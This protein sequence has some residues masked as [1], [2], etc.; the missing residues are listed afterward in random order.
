MPTKYLTIKF[1]E[2]PEEGDKIR[3]AIADDTATFGVY[4]FSNGEYDA[5]LT[6]KQQ[7]GKTCNSIMAFNSDWSMRSSF[8]SPGVVG[9]EAPGVI[10]TGDTLSGF[11]YDA[12]F[13]GAQAV[14]VGQFDE[15]NG[16]SS[17][18]MV[19]IDR[20]GNLLANLSTSFGSATINCVRYDSSYGILFGTSTT[21]FNGTTVRGFSRLSSGFSLDTTFNN[22]VI[23][24]GLVN[25]TTQVTALEVCPTTD[26]IYVGY[27]NSTGGGRVVRFNTDGT[28][29]ATFTAVV[30][31]NATTGSLVFIRSIAIDPNNGF[32]L[33]GGNFNDVNSTAQRLVV[34]V[35]NT[36]TPQDFITLSG[37]TDCRAI[38]L[39]EDGDIAYIGV[40][41]T[42]VTKDIIPAQTIYDISGKG[43]IKVETASGDTSN[44]FNEIIGSGIRCY[45]GNTTYLVND[46]Q[47]VEQYGIDNRKMLA[48]GGKFKT[49]GDFRAE[50]FACF[51]LEFGV[52]AIWTDVNDAVPQVDTLKFTTNFNSE[53]NRLL[54][55]KVSQGGGLTTLPNMFLALGS[56]DIL[57][58]IQVDTQF[59]PSGSAPYGTFNI[60][61]NIEIGQYKTNT[62]SVTFTFSQANECEGDMSILLGNIYNP[63]TNTYDAIGETF[64]FRYDPDPGQVQIGAFVGSTMVNFKNALIDR[65]TPYFDDLL[66]YTRGYALGAGVRDFTWSIE[67]IDATNLK[68]TTNNP[69]WR[70]GFLTTNTFPDPFIVA[71]TGEAITY[72]SSFADTYW[73]TYH[74]LRAEYIN[75]TGGETIVYEGVL[76][77][78][79]DDFYYVFG[80]DVIMGGGNLDGS[81]ISLSFEYDNPAPPASPREVS[82]F[83]IIQLL[84][85]IELFSEEQLVDGSETFLV[86][87]PGFV[88]TT[89]GTTYSTFDVYT[90]SGNI[91]DNT[92]VNYSV[93]KQKIT[94][95]Q[96][97]L[98]IDVS[99][100]TKENLEAD[101]TNYV[102]D[103]PVM[104]LG[105]NESRWVKVIINNFSGTTQTSQ[106][107]KYYYIMD[108]FVSPLELNEKNT[109]PR[110]LTPKTNIMARGTAPRIYFRNKGVVS[111]GGNSAG[112]P[113]VIDP[114]A[115]NSEN[116][117]YFNSIYVPTYLGE[118]NSITFTILYD[119][120]TTE[121][122]TY[123]VY[124]EC[125]YD[126]Y[127]LIFKNKWGVLESLPVSKKSVKSLNVEGNDYLRSIVDINGD[128]NINRHTNKQF[129]V[130]GYEEWILNTPFIPEY[131]N[132]SI[133]Q[134]M[135]SEEIWVRP[136]GYFQFGELVQ[137]QVVY[138]AV[139]LDQNITFKT[140][141]NDR[142]IQ[143]TIKVKLSHNEVKNIL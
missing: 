136:V 76:N 110:I 109:L 142:L 89:S 100:L 141:N 53:I 18:N 42:R 15:Y 65:F 20:N 74:K 80:S 143:Y 129:N 79:N 138:P 49:F 47:V 102:S 33:I 32:I 36:G 93:T 26:K 27:T 1:Y 8:N 59:T 84:G 104:E 123:T 69:I 67:I 39:D 90:Y 139:R 25:A 19:A 11:I 96:T 21:L 134:A 124:D 86:R 48:V 108:G 88:K 105:E 51:D 23:A 140:L 46:I 52:P 111:I 7:S 30:C 118:N 126:I 45:S 106:D 77:Q 4:E 56:Y 94:P 63:I 14:L 35:N 41:A 31:S 40:N 2:Q 50:N 55:S 37:G 113:F 24:T 6:Y 87:S 133:K 132:E 107:I 3:F 70:N 82:F 101:I 44:N 12:D 127:E 92:P 97:T 119:D 38:T 68:I 71:N 16:Y 117:Q 103:T 83:N 57:K 137:S 99:N 34:K 130:G 95:T 10:K 28:I 22:N 29:D 121:V 85:E 75:S 112:Y 54:V 114:N 78:D 64:E 9:V 135:L 81:E 66:L 62:D 125:K 13:D 91:Y 122:I 128:Y 115:F 58:G 72:N 60:M 61:K 120:D 131:M 43:I 5:E 73:N 116:N 17:R 98:Y